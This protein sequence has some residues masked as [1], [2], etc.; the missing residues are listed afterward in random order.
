MLNMYDWKV[1][2]HYKKD[3]QITEELFDEERY[4]LSFPKSHVIRGLKKNFK[5]NYGLLKY[6][7]EFAITGQVEMWMIAERKVVEYHLIEPKGDRSAITQFTKGRKLAAKDDRKEEAI[8]ALDLAIKK[9]ENHA[10]AY[11]RRAYVNTML[12]KYHDAIR[13]YTKSINIYAGV[14]EPYYGRAYVHEVQ[15]N[16]E[17]AASDFDTAIK[18]SIPLQPIHWKSRRKKAECLMRLGETEEAA[19]E[20]R[21]FTLRNFSEDNPNFAYRKK[22]YFDYG[23]CQYRLGN[24]KEAAKLFDTALSIKEG[25]R[26]PKREE[27]LFHRGKARQQ[28]KL[29]NFEGDLKIAAKAGFD[30]SS[31]A[32]EEE[33]FS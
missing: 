22:V 16:F 3:V 10:Q 11:E 19:K 8:A 5:G 27:I 1:A 4:C 13:D 14:P 33:V 30:I 7:S 21:F 31:V 26:A 24:Y 25:K 12:K 9:Y 18:R 32:L 29:P 15:E 20:L 2:N 17:Q 28:A 23:R 6:L